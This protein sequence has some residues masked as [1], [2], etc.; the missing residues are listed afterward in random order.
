MVKADVA[1]LDKLL[2]PE[3]SYTHNN[4]QVQDKGAFVGD[5][6]GGA[7]TYLGVP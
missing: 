2:A 6:K 7:I 1:A 4:A 5:I 3:L